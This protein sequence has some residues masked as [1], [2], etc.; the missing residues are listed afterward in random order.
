MGCAVDKIPALCQHQ[1]VRGQ[2]HGRFYYHDCDDYPCGACGDD[3][4]IICGEGMQSCSLCL[5]VAEALCDF[6]MGEGKTCDL[7]LCTRHRIAQ[8]GEIDD[9]DYCPQHARMA[10]G[11]V[12]TPTVED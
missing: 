5:H 1:V 7:P 9:I 8:A 10:A 3:I 11:I 2:A 6:P 4:I 12:V